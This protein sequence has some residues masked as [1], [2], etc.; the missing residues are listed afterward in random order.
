MTKNNGYET[1]ESSLSYVFV[2]FFGEQPC[3]K[4]GNIQKVV[5]CAY[6]TNKQMHC[7]FG[8]NAK[9]MSIKQTMCKVKD[10]LTKALASLFASLMFTEFL[11][12][13]L[14]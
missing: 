5:M 4:S 3:T 6:T 7:D 12:H 2:D 1:W 9:F 13:S 10:L 14:Y 8:I 11:N